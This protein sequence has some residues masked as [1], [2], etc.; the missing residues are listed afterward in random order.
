MTHR[1][2]ALSLG[3]GNWGAAAFPGTGGQWEPVQ[4]SQ[5]PAV[6][7]V[8]PP[9]FLSCG[10]RVGENKAGTD[11]V[12]QLYLFFYPTQIRMKDFHDHLVYTYLCFPAESKEAQCAGLSCF[13][14]CSFHV[15]KE[16]Y[17]RAERNYCDRIHFTT[18]LTVAALRWKTM[19]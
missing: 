6:N 7:P 5:P 12:P 10:Q 4:S 15:I 8:T 14:F 2:V 13:L 16:T 17:T 1:S 3:R 18:H 19:N 9:P 11:S